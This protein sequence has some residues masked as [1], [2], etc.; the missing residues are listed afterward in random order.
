MQSI[1]SVS[2]GA[3]GAVLALAPWAGL[4]LL[5]GLWA[6]RFLPL[7]LGSHPACQALC[8]QTHPPLA[9]SILLPSSPSFFI[10]CHGWVSSGIHSSGDA[11][12]QEPCGMQGP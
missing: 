12:C 1:I 10:L 6:P 2:M 5:L 8:E 3:V 7:S 9:V 11:H 4:W